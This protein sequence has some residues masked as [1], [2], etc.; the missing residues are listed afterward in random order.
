M[1]NRAKQFA[2]FAA[3]K[4]YEEELYKE[5]KKLTYEDRREISEDMAMAINDRLSSLQVGEMVEIEHYFKGRYVKTKGVVE[6]ISN[7]VKVAGKKIRFVDIY[8]I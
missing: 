2:P 8:R 4:G 1:D 6:E 7:Y 3:L 5:E